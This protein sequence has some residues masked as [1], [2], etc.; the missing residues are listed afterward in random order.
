MNGL[1]PSLCIGRSPLD[2]E[3]WTFSS[4][5]PLYTTCPAEGRRGNRRRMDSFIRILY[6][7]VRLVSG[8]NILLEFS[9]RHC[10]SS[11]GKGF[12]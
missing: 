1:L 10:V 12:L 11:N 4:S 9:V 3:R 2:V 5:S 8:D 6:G 7:P